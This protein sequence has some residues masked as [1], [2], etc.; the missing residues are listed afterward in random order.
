[1]SHFNRLER[2]AAVLSYIIIILAGLAWWLYMQ[3]AVFRPLPPPDNPTSPDS[4]SSGPANSNPDP[5][6]PPSDTPCSQSLRALAVR[7]EG[8][9]QREAAFMQ[10]IAELEDELRN[11][12][13]VRKSV[14]ERYD[15][16]VRE[17]GVERM[18]R[19]RSIGE[20][21][22]EED[23]KREEEVKGKGGEEGGAEGSSGGVAAGGQEEAAEVRLG[24]GYK[25]KRQESR[26]RLKY[27]IVS[28]SF[29][30]EGGDK[31]AHLATRVLAQQSRNDFV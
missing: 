27:L 6:S 19:E 21:M 18:E 5:S 4:T 22:G 8:Q 30:L 15:E 25:G 14:E 20:C 11:E 7:V 23:K 12:K 13:V 17:Q 9:E 2:E 3:P 16:R 26:P 29:R 1:M 28:F 31:S 10:R 24:N